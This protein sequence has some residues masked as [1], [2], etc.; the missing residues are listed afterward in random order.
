[1][2]K[3]TGTAKDQAHALTEPVGRSHTTMAR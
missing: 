1:L 2:L 3:K